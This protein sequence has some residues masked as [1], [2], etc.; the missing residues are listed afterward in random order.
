MKRV[1]W[2]NLN[3]TQ[4]GILVSLI[5]VQLSLF[6]AAITSIAKR[7]A[8]EIKGRKTWWCLFSL[9]N[10]I[11]PICYFIFGRTRPGIKRNFLQ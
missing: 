5:L 4:K 7:S 3:D 9:V 2:K 11:G 10:Y 1:A 8:Y 6:I